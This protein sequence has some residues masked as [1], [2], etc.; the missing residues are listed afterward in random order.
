MASGGR[1]L[2]RACSGTIRA[3]VGSSRGIPEANVTADPYIEFNMTVRATYRLTVT[4]FRSA[5][6]AVLP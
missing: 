6:V 2:R 4:V 3:N 1:T 5:M